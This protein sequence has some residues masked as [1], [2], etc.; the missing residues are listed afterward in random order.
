[1]VFLVGN[2]MLSLRSSK[3]FLANMNCENDIS[4]ESKLRI[5]NSRQSRF[6]SGRAYP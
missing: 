6:S 2:T 4:M 1:M 5:D 3:Y